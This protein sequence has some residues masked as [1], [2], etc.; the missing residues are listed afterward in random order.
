MENQRNEEI[1]LYSHLFFL[2]L[3]F[4]TLYVYNLFNN[5]CINFPSSNI[6]SVFFFKFY[7]IFKLYIIVLVLPN[8]NIKLFCCSNGNTFILP[9]SLLLFHCLSHSKSLVYLVISLSIYYMQVL[10]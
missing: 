3:Y 5:K 4:C 8:I 7:F 6:F 10:C 9:A 1:K 2:K